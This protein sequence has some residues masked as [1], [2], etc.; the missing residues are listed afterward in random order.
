MIH[1]TAI[2]DPGAKIGE[3]VTI[4]AFTVIGAHVEIGDDCVI[5]PHVVINGPTVIGK[6]NRIYQFASVGEDC[7]DLKYKGEPTRLIIGDDNTIREFTTLHRGTIQDSEETRIGSHNL[8][9]AY[10]HVA[11]DCII[12]NHCILAN[13]TQVAGHCVIGN[14]AIL[15]GNSGI[16]QFCQIGEHAFVGTGSTVLKDIPAYVTVQGFPA[17]PHGMNMEGLKRRGF[18]REAMKALRHAYKVVYRE[19]NTLKEALAELE[20]LDPLLPEVRVFIESIQ[21]SKRGIAR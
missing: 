6:R 19:G 1:E 9:M 7:Q 8:F 15:G 16:H 4:G 2:I 12:G 20:S 13:A 11:H 21:A 14:H 18:S 17:S 10:S 5:S 3:N